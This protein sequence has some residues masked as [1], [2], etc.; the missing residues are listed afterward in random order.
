MTGT[1]RHTWFSIAVVGVLS[2][3]YATVNL[4]FVDC[5]K[6]DCLGTVQYAC[7]DC[8]TGFTTQAEWR[9]HTLHKHPHSAPPP[10]MHISR[11]SDGGLNVTYQC[12]ICDTGFIADAEWEQHIT[13]QHPGKK[14]SIPAI[15]LQKEIEESG[16]KKT[17]YVHPLIG[18]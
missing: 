5:A 14:A 7:Q 1:I 12:P 17:V 8:E 3:A 15:R 11:M 4:M 2:A 9:E 18:Q 10:L 6:A 13:Q 16:R